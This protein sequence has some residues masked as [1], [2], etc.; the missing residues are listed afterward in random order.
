MLAAAQDD[1]QMNAQENL[2]TMFGLSNEE[3][4]Q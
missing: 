1:A 4:A 2:S 3:V